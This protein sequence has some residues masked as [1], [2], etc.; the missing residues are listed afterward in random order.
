MAGSGGAKRIDPFGGLAWQ[1]VA[2]DITADIE[3][4]VIPPG[5]RLP[6]EQALAETYGCA[7]VTIRRALAHLRER[8]LI[9]TAHGR[10]SYAKPPG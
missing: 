2:D 3:T 5:I 6:S 10:G 8:G 9:V 1:Q 4:G 7:R